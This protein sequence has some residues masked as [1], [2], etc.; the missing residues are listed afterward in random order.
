M[1]KRTKKEFQL[2]MI[3]MGLLIIGMGFYFSYETLFLT[4]DSFRKIRG[5]IASSTSYVEPVVGRGMHSYRAT[6]E[7]RIR[8]LSNTFRIF[9][10]IGQQRSHLEYDRVK[11]RLIRHKE[12]ILTIPKKQLKDNSN[13]IEL[14][15]DDQLVIGKDQTLDISNSSFWTLAIMGLTFIGFSQT[16]SWWKFLH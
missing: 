7:F 1:W 5:Q 15:I 9:E 11:R 12:V 10:N 14:Y 13:F 16:Y 2:E 3:F 4:E 6:L 8:G